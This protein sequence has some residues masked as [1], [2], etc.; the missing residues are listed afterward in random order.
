MMKMAFHNSYVTILYYTG[1]LG[2]SFLL[3][4]LYRFLRIGMYYS[5]ASATAEMQRMGTTLTLAFLFY[6]IVAFFNVILEGP[7]SAM[8][9]W[10]IPGLILVLGNQDRRLKEVATRPDGDD[11][12]Q[13]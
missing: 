7:Q 2:I 3:I 4:M 9:Y 13:N 5:R 1:L 10:L 6:S 11:E 8:V 12:R